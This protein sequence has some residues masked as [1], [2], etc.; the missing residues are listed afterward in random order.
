MRVFVYYDMDHG[1]MEV[2][3]TLEEAK[4]HADECWPDSI[5]EEWEECGDSIH[6]SEYQSIHT[7]FVR[8][9]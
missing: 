9:D 1:D 4:A 2:F 8:F 5:D 7:K 3:P 6:R